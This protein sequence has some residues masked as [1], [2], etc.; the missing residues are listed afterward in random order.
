MDKEIKDLLENEVLGEEAKLALQEAFDNKVK[1]AEHK[2]QEDYAVRYA[3]DKT[4]LVEAM[5][6]LLGDTIRTELTEFAEDRSALVKQRAKLSQETMNVKKK[7]F[8]K[9]AEHTK[10]LNAYVDKQIRSE[11]VEF[12]DDRKSLSKQRQEMAKELQTV[13]ESSTR[14]LKNRVNKL[15]TFVLKQLSEEIAEFQSDKKALVEQRVKL[16]QTGKKKLQEVQ[17]KFIERA[18]TAVSKTLDDVI[19]TELVQW[20]EDIKA[21][22]ENNFGRRIFEAV[23]AEYMASYLSEGSEVKKLDR[24]LQEQKAALAEA[25]KAL[26]EKQTLVETSSAQARNAENRIKRV[27]V[28]NDLLAPL[29]RDKKAVMED[30]LRDIKT[31]NLKE[32]FTRYLP[33]VVNGA[34]VEQSK[35]KL[36]ENN[37]SK[38]SKAV[39]STGDRTN[40]KLAQAVAEE[41]NNDQDQD[42]GVIL[43]LAGIKK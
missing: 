39:A 20:R 10:L 24:Q 6:K 2:L 11:I 38:S 32:A 37:Q 41:T 22:R 12:V 29:S 26:S 9:L 18:G 5:E 7:Y 27:E 15:E 25:Q 31:Q 8:A 40:N 21:A 35:T 3:N 1:V 36:T 14:E 16:A 23:A 4:A 17:S 30:L 34:K 43:H 42:I 33:A 19:K 28:L 13:R